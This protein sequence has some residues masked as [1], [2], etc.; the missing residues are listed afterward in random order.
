MGGGLLQQVNRD[1][2]KFAMKCSA[3]KINGH[4]QDVYKDP[5]TDKGKISKRGRLAL[6]HPYGF[7]TQFCTD[8]KENVKLADNL[9]VP[10]FRNG[11]ILKTYTFAEIRERSGR[12]FV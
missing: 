10:V 4:W 8:R 2:M 6:T 1:T 3:I 9:L 12:E 7:N 5:A 11:Q